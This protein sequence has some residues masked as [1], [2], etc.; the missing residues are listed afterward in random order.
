MLSIL[1]S[2]ERTLAMLTENNISKYFYGCQQ[3]VSNQG[4]HLSLLE[5]RVK[6]LQSSPLKTPELRVFLLFI[7]LS[8]NR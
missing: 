1:H 5:K 2:S 3:K 4:N 6:C 8:L 7:L